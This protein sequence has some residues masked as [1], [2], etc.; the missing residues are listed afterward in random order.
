[1][2]FPG[3]ASGLPKFGAFKCKK[4]GNWARDA[5]EQV[6]ESDVKEFGTLKEVET[7]GREEGMIGL[8]KG[9]YY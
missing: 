2:R 5:A 4:E 7:E 8:Q 3:K 9:T 1:V 6:V